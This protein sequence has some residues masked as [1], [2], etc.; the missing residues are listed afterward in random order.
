MWPIKPSAPSSCHQIPICCQAS[1]SHSNST[2]FFVVSMTTSILSLTPLYSY[3]LIHNKYSMKKKSLDCS[4]HTSHR[5]KDKKYIWAGAND[6]YG[7]DLRK[8]SRGQ[9]KGR[10]MDPEGTSWVTHSITHLA[11]K[12]CCTTTRSNRSWIM[13]ASVRLPKLPTAEIGI[14]SWFT[15]I[16][17]KLCKR[18][19]VMSFS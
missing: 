3:S 5:S 9:G 15:N 18:C 13:A 8:E 2:H 7:Q 17:G 19:L 14:A 16:C 4:E 6:T 12:N 11:W 1:Q 10:K